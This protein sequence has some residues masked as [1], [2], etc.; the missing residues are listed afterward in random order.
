MKTLKFDGIGMYTNFAGVYLGN[1]T[2][3]PIFK[4]INSLSA[5]VF[6]HPA[7]P[8]CAGAS[9]GYPDP[10]SEYPFESVRAMEN[11]LLTGQ[12]ANYSKINIIFPHGGG[13][14]PY[15]GTRIAGMASLAFLGGRSVTYVYLISL[16]ISTCLERGRVILRAKPCHVIFNINLTY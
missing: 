1:S 16:L 14:M 3:N 7:A 12:R 10:M 11:L 5:P 13:A 6:V 8:S 4:L 15:L 2:L 9:L